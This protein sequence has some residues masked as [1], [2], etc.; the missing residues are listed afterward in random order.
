M[1]APLIENHY[2][3]DIDHDLM[4]EGHKVWGFVIYRCTYKDDEKW[5]NFMDRFRLEMERQM[6]GS[7]GR[8]LLKKL[9]ITVLED[10]SWE[11]ASTASIRA[12]FQDWCEKNAQR[13]QRFL[14]ESNHRI[15]KGWRYNIC[16]HMNSCALESFDE[17]A[18]PKDYVNLISRSWLSLRDQPHLL[19]EKRQKP[20]WW[21]RAWPP[22]PPEYDELEGNTEEDVGWMMME[23]DSLVP[24]YS[25]LGRLNSWLTEYKRPPIVVFNGY[26]WE[27]S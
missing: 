3:M 18:D 6:D 26:S 19:V 4:V 15:W 23:L 2:A 24:M 20:S 13:E 8:A 16:I 10:P 25:R 5:K 9:D 22:V 12:H 1:S 17:G 7:E 27:R 14:L 21:K 11:D